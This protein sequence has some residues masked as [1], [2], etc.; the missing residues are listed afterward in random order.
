M[1]RL[2]AVI[3]FVSI[4]GSLMA[5]NDVSFRKLNAFRPNY[6]IMGI[7]TNQTSTKDNFDIKFQISLKLDICRTVAGRECNVFFNYTQ[8]SLWN[9]L[10]YS[11]P[12]RDNMYIPGLYC[13]LPFDIPGREETGGRF[14]FGLVHRSNGRDDVYSRSINYIMADYLLPVNRC[15]E[16]EAAARCGIGFVE[17]D[18]GQ[19]MFRYLGYVGFA[20]TYTDM[21]DDFSVSVSAVPLF[22][23]AIPLN[24][25][26]QAAYCPFKDK[27]AP[28][29]FMQFHYGY[30]E[31]LRDCVPLIKPMPMLRLGVT[32]Q[33]HTA[34][35]W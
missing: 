8:V 10:A 4:A 11:S 22:G 32:L 15:F 5:G 31:A 13:T 33:T 16:L 19:D 14:M 2:A 3:L 21:S 12:F 24:V 30:D 28:Y 25:T 18:M 1:F 29:L 26:C 27:G 7:P 9:I 20:A 6:F 34:L 35:F 17:E 23:R